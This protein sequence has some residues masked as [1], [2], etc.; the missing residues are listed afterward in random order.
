MKIELPTPAATRNFGK[1]L[2]T[3]LER[4]VVIS[5]EGP[6]GVGKTTLI[7]G[8]AEGLKVSEQLTSPTFILFRLLPVTAKNKAQI[9]W[10]VHADAYRIKKPSELFDAGLDDYLHDPNTVSIIEWGNKLK[11]YYVPN[12][13]HVR[14]NIGSRTEPRSVVFPEKFFGVPDAKFLASIMRSEKHKK[15][16]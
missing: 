2:S 14:M 13:V 11:G 4:G 10:L 8:I 3:R 9:K 1:W 7:K 16:R 15:P 12:L 5:L 6:I